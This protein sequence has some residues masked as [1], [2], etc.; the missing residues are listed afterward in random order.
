L[1]PEKSPVVWCSPKENLYDLELLPVKYTQKMYDTVFFPEY[2]KE[3][4]RSWMD[5]L[6]V[7]YVAFTRAETNLLVLAGHKRK[8]ESLDDIKTVSDL[9]QYIVPELNGDY[10]PETLRFERGKL[11]FPEAKERKI[12]DNIL[13]QTPR[14]LDVTFLSEP[15]ET[16][17]TIFRQS[18]KSREFISSGDSAANRNE[19]IRRG[20][21]MHRLFSMLTTLDDIGKAVDRLSFEGLISPEE[22]QE[23][24]GFVKRAIEGSGNKKWFSGDYRAYNE[25]TILLKENGEA[26]TRRPDKV[27][28]KDKT[29]IVIDYKFGAPHAGHQ[30]QM[31]QYVSLMQRM[32]Y[33]N[34]EGHI[35]YI[36]EETIRAY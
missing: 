12:S 30:K 19:Y 9:L 10:N 5:N 32:G 6:N 1:Y 23:Y 11:E 22:K 16:G 3:T 2:E 17:K 26:T 18:N 28:V 21:L 15:F 36:T 34:V 14:M 20:N 8:L 24:A 27:L 7:L 4:C 33:E 31:N 13:K 29:A 35:W 25:C